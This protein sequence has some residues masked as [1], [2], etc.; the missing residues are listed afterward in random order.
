MQRY[1]ENV[2]NDNRSEK[3]NYVIG[4]C[5]SDFDLH[6]VTAKISICTHPIE[7]EINKGSCSPLRIDFDE[8][9]IPDNIKHLLQIYKEDKRHSLS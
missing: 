8:T 5:V 7:K 6:N 3:E 9:K 4:L 1:R 2:V